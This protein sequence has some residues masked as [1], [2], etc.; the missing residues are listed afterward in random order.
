MDILAIQK[1]LK[2][3]HI[4]DGLENELERMRRE[5]NQLFTIDSYLIGT[6]KNHNEVLNETRN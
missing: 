3:D 6:G 5:I 1:P 2:N 4:F